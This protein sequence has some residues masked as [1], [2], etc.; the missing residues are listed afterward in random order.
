[1]RLLIYD[2]M[3]LKCNILSNLDRFKNY[4][5][6]HRVKIAIIHIWEVQLEPL[7]LH[8]LSEV[9]LI[10]ASLITLIIR[11]YNQTFNTERHIAIVIIQLWG[12]IYYSSNQM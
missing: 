2:R 1:M 6:M 9:N 10:P 11:T 5:L 4:G 7:H 3:P 8:R 12:S